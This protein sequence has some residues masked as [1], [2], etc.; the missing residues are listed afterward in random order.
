MH[1]EAMQSPHVTQQV[2]VR[3]GRGQGSKQVSVEL[4]QGSKNGLEW[5]RVGEGQEGGYLEEPTRGGWKPHRGVWALVAKQ[6]PLEQ[7]TP[8]LRKG[9]FSR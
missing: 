7:T 2:R 3:A 9:P 1:G 4:L 6:P 8:S 5:D